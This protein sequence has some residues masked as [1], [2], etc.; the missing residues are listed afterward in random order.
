MFTD[1]RETAPLVVDE[2][3]RIGGLIYRLNDRVER[4]EHTRHSS[5]DA[6]QEWQEARQQLN[7]AKREL[8]KCLKS[9]PMLF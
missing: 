2:L 5:W 3:E 1:T 8:K 7:A 4:L 9:R 6:Q